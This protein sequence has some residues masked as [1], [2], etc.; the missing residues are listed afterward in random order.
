M[1]N[2]I[3][4]IFEAYKGITEDLSETPE[5][6]KIVD[7]KGNVFYYKD[8]SCKILH[9]ESGPAIQWKNG[10]QMWYIEGK[11]Y[12]DEEFFNYVKKNKK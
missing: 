5:E 7:V 11:R 1:N 8:K 9:R 10:H 4:A 3:Q 6:N 12:T 2:D